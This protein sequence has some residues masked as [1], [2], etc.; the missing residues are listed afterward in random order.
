M[1]RKRVAVLGCTGSIGRQTLDVISGHPERFELSGLVAGRD[2]A[3]LEAQAAGFT[4]VAT[5]LGAEDAVAMAGSDDV[6][7]VVNAI[8]GSAGLRASV[9][10]LGSGKVLA[11][12]NKESLV[13]GGEACASAARSGG[14]SIVPVDSEHAALT[15]CLIGC[16]RRDV[17]RI[18]LTASGGPF[19]N[20]QDLSAVTRD[21]ALAHPT[22][23]M[24][25]KITV[26][27]ATLMNKGLEVIEAHFLFEMHYDMID[28]VVHP[29][30]IVHGMVVLNDGSVMMQAAP[31]D[32]RI[33]IAAALASPGRMGPPPASLDL[34]ATGSLTFE[35]V[36]R[37]RFR[38]LDLAYEAGRRGDSYPAVLNAAN[39]EAVA[40]FLDERIALTG[41][42]EVVEGALDAHT[43][44][45]A[46][47]VEAVLEAD[48]WARSRASSL[49]DAAGVG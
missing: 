49:M 34:V 21:E 47:S 10:A 27:S 45:G 4:G 12:A 3:A 44:H 9:A 26:D 17:S 36:D 40:A 32:M 25:P 37:S 6:D 16:D 28:V 11:L 23:S 1:Q 20:T 18:V 13:A 19:R 48:A 5:G 30:S 22:W 42:P 43:P 38:S 35:E 29:Q 46:D 33:P 15:Q 2:R 14:G 39:E 8:V 31:P 41:I 7:V 24:G